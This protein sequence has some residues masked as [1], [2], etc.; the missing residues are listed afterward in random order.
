MKFNAAVTIIYNL[1][2]KGSGVIICGE[3]R[4]P[5][6]FVFFQLDN[7][8]M[9]V[10]KQII[11]SK[12]MGTLW[13][14]PEPGKLVEGFRGNLEIGILLVVPLYCIFRRKVNDDAKPF[15][16]FMEYLIHKWAINTPHT[17]TEALINRVMPYLQ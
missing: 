4:F 5:P 7:Q 10:Y 6:N 16:D 2:S 1:L 17:E 15:V 8:T 14:Q 11:G 13:I 9:S 12:T 3:D